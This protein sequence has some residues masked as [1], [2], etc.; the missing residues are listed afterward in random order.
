[1]ILYEDETMV[2]WTMEGVGLPPVKAAETKEPAD[3]WVSADANRRAGAGRRPRKR[4]R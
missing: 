3:E 1:M 4:C 2:V